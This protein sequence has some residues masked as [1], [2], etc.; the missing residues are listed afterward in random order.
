MQIAKQKRKENIGEYL[1]YMF[2]IED[3]I[4]ACQLNPVVIE[5]KLIS[6]YNTNEDGLTEIRNWYLGLNELMVE[7]KLHEKGHLSFLKN[8]MTEV[9]DFHLFLLQSEEHT[10]YR[11]TYKKC[12][13][14]LQSLKKEQGLNEVELMVSFIYSI[15]VAKLKNQQI[16]EQVQ[17]SAIQVSGVLAQLSSK[18]SDYEKGLLK[19]E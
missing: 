18:F 10:A 1:L 9:F 12:L 16:P 19:I 17:Q 3:L 8:T 6:Q 4:R 5:N 14:I 2:Q 11:V 7:E 15:F 13:L